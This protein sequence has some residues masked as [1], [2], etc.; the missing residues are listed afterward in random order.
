MLSSKDLL[1]RTGISRATLNN[2]IAAGLIGRPD[3]LPPGPDDGG[4]PRLGYFPDDTIERLETIQR[5]KREGWSLGRIVEYFLRSG[6]HTPPPVTQAPPARP[7]VSP[8]PARPRHL[9]SSQPDRTPQLMTVAVLAVGLQD[10]DA[11]WVTLSVHDFFE[12]S[13]ELDAEVRRFVRARNGQ[14]VRLAPYRFIPE[15]FVPHAHILVDPHDAGPHRVR[16]SA[17]A[18]CSAQRPHRGFVG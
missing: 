15:L 11:L 16:L 9:P 7:P 1:E 18:A 12:L 8:E 3:V 14:A 5:L 4:A 10:A 13:A 17:V 6:D 2:Y